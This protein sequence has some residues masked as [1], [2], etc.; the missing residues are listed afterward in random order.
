MLLSRVA[1]RRPF[2]YLSVINNIRVYDGPCCFFFATLSRFFWA[3][4]FCHL[5]CILYFMILSTSIAVLFRACSLAV[6]CLCAVRMLV[7]CGCAF[8]QRGFD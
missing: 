4:G 7:F 6:V 8:A 3:S 1:V 2:A 5:R